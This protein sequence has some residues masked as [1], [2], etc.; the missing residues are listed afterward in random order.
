MFRN[1]LIVAALARDVSAIVSKYPTPQT[2]SPLNGAPFNTDT[3][4]GDLG[5]MDDPWT[6]VYAP[7]VYQKPEDNA[8]VCMAGPDVDKDTCTLFQIEISF[9]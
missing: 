7:G 9:F 1:G 3:A 8:N 2:P 5:R 6:I 4:M